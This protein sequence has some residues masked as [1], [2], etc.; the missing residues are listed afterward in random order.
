MVAGMADERRERERGTDHGDPSLVID[1]RIVMA[2]PD[3]PLP[4]DLPVE[5]LSI[6]PRCNVV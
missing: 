2:S 4:L 3:H 1:G 5:E 6:Q